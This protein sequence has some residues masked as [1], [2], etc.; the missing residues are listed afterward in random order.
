MELKRGSRSSLVP[1]VPPSNIK[2]HFA[3]FLYFIFSEVRYGFNCEY[4]C[5]T[6]VN[7][8]CGDKH[9]QQTQIINFNDCIG[10]NSTITMKSL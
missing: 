8:I 7:R 3:Y 6:C 5:D 2:Y 9:H 1:D 10:R 4:H